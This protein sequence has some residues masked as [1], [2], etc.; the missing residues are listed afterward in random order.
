MAVETRSDDLI[1]RKDPAVPGAGPF[2]TGPGQTWYMSFKF[3]AEFTFALTLLVVTAPLLLLAAIM[4]KLSSRGPVFY[5]Q[6]RLGRFGQPFMIH[7]I[8]TMTHNCE[9]LSGAQW[10]VPGDSRVTF[11]G[12]FLR[13][14]HIDELPQ[15]WNVLR[16]DMSIVGPR[17]ERP[18]FI[19]QLERALPCYRDRLLVRPGITGLAQIQLPPDTDLKSVRRKLA[20]DLYYVRQVGLW[21][22]IRIIL[23]TGFNFLFIPW[24]KQLLLVPCGEKIERSYE[25]DFPALPELQPV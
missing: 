24:I 25:N 11:V 9:S 22:D 7:K 14:T 5:S 3:L 12:R 8:R 23:C 17:P 2:F 15:L 16:G 1:W 19:P 10:S 20:H 18:E 4:V 13:R 21:L 6:I